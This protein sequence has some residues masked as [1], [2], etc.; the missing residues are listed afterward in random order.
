[1]RD[2]NPPLM[3]EKTFQINV[4]ESEIDLVSCLLACKPRLSISDGRRW[5]L[6]LQRGYRTT[7]WVYDVHYMLLIS[8]PESKVKFVA[9]CIIPFLI[10]DVHTVRCCSHMCLWFRSFASFFRKCALHFQHSH[11]GVWT[12]APYII[13]VSCVVSLLF[14]DN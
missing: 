10:F 2:E 9:A 4:M 13:Y 11:T 12:L 5:T 1:M 14:A 7:L 6:N 3:K 8:P